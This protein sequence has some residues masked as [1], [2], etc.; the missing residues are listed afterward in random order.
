MKSLF[1][2]L[3]LVAVAVQYAHTEDKFSMID[4]KDQFSKAILSMKG[5]SRSDK[6]TFNKFDSNIQESMQ[7]FIT[8]SSAITATVQK[9]IE[10]LSNG[11]KMDIV[12]RLPT[13]TLAK[14]VAQEFCDL[15]K[16]MKA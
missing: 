5:S 7:K 11:F 1:V 10:Q 15:C 9:K 2:A 4:C 6:E 13:P 16:D 12:N 14:N 3:F 8:N